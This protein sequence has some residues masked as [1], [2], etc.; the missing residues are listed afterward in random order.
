VASVRIASLAPEAVPDCER[1]LRS[2]PE[3]FGI[4]EAV[5]RYVE[6]LTAL[7]TF[8]ALVDGEVAGFIALAQPLPESVELHVMAI[9][10]GHHREGIGRLLIRRAQAWAVERQ[11]CVLHVMTLAVSAEYPPYESTR[12]FYRAMGFVPLLETTAPWGADNP[13][14]IM[15][16]VLSAAPAV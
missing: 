10:P 3:W 12:A 11:A 1:I 5:D 8:V 15:V 6:S 7:R 2:L 16:R 9:D 4:P 14:L 13:A